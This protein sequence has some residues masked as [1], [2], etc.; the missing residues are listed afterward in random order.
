MWA[1]SPGLELNDLGVIR[2]ADD[3]QSWFFLNYRQTDPGKVFRR[4][5]FW[6]NPSVGFNYGALTQDHSATEQGL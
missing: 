5:N 4:Y 2:R 3:I 1:D 6:I